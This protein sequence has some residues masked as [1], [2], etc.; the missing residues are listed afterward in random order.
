[1]EEAPPAA[2]PARLDAQVTVSLEQAREEHEKGQMNTA[3]EELGGPATR[4]Q[5]LLEWRGAEQESE[6]AFDDVIE[7]AGADKTCG[8]EHG[9]NKQLA[10]G[11]VR[12][13]GLQH[14]AADIAPV[15]EKDGRA[16]DQE[17]ARASDGPLRRVGGVDPQKRFV[18]DPQPYQSI[19]HIVGGGQPCDQ[20]DKG[21]EIEIKAANHRQPGR[22]RSCLLSHCSRPRRQ[23]GRDFRREA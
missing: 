19:N 16:D 10:Q 14:Q 17:P 2:G 12:L 18:R 6:A 9:V 23:G 8:R 5:L 20:T 21:D 13:T 4:S 11:R 3:V 7:G 22:F 1:M 15:D